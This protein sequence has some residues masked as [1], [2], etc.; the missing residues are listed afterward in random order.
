M[1]FILFSSLYKQYNFASTEIKVDSG[2][3]QGSH[4]G[5]LLLLMFINDIVDNF[6]FCKFMMFT[7]DLKIFM[8]IRSDLG[9]ARFQENLDRFHESCV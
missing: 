7:Y 8:V 1:V 3:P 4:L 6:M 2:V 5:P 9:V